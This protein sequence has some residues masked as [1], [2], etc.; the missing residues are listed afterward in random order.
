MEID[1]NSVVQR[2]RNLERELQMLKSGSLIVQQEEKQE[3]FD[4]NDIIYYNNICS[5]T[6]VIT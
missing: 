5:H 6:I 4:E 3:V 2:M 1:Y